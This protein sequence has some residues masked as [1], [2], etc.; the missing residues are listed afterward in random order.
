MGSLVTLLRNI[1]TKAGIYLELMSDHF[2]NFK[3]CKTEAFMQDDAPC[4]SA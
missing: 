1:M 3:P 2:D 4:N